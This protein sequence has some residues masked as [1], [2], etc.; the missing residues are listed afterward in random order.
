MYIWKCRPNVSWFFHLLAFPLPFFSFRA[1]ISF[2]YRVNG[3]VKLM[4]FAYR[5][6]RRIVG[7]C[8][9]TFEASEQAGVWGWGQQI[10]IEYEL[11]HG[12]SKCMHG[13]YKRRQH[14][15]WSRHL[16]NISNANTIF[17]LNDKYYNNFC[18]FS[19]SV[20]SNNRFPFIVYL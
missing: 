2:I 13:K 9:L 14:F 11:R 12:D 5:D 18:D 17:A 4:P 10:F 3:G 8:Q 1:H 16:R 19:Y 6:S 7:K 20:P 15:N